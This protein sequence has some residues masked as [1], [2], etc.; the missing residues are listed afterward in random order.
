MSN[1]IKHQQRSHRNHRKN[2]EL[3]FRGFATSNWVR[4]EKKKGSS[5]IQILMGMFH[6]KQGKQGGRNER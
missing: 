5:F 1:R 4:D 3:V 6:R 2:S